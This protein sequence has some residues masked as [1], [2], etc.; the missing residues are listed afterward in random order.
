MTIAT[1]LYQKA[2]HPTRDARSAAYQAGVLDTLNFKESGTELKHPFEPG[3]AEADAWFAGNQ[4]GH[5]LWRDHQ[6]DGK[7]E[8]APIVPPA[9][10]SQNIIA[11]RAAQLNA[12]LV[13]ISGGG[14]ESFN[15]LAD[16]LKDN[17]IWGC[18]TLAEDILYH[19]RHEDEH[20]QGGAK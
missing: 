7:S 12:L 17:V 3:S 4:E 9:N 6:E 16:E 8:H 14:F 10:A 20:L 1:Q 2:F 11:E 19:L 5:N 18:Q 15:G 13:C